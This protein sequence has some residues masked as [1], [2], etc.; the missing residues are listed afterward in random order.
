MQDVSG[1]T[2]AAPVWQDVIL[3]L[4][5]H[6]PSYAPTPP[7][8][9]K[10]VMTTFSPAVESPRR[11]WFMKDTTLMKVAAIAAHSQMVHIDSPANGM[12]IAID[13]DI[14]SADQR[15]P[16][17]VKGATRD[18]QLKLNNKVIGSAA[19]QVLWPPKHGSYYL[20]VE[21]DHHHVMDRILFTVR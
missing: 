12:V 7:E 4:H 11:E 1:I 16:F 19:Q 20:S 8:G 15:V 13:P 21:D 9:V 14:P 18:M 5:D 6:E 17:T 3:A 2:G 10:S